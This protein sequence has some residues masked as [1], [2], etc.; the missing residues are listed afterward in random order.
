ME[1]VFSLITSPDLLAMFWLAVI[2][3]QQGGNVWNG[4]VTTNRDPPFFATT[5]DLRA[6][7]LVVYTDSTYSRQGKQSV[8]GRACLERRIT[9]PLV[10]PRRGD[11]MIDMSC[12]LRV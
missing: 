3:Y 6:R 4:T 8:L 9:T 12:V 11:E 10:S 1:R 7:S 5:T 2:G